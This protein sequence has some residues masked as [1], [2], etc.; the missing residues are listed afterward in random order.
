MSMIESG[1]DSIAMERLS[2]YDRELQ[3]L[4]AGLCSHLSGKTISVHER[5]HPRQALAN[6][7]LSIPLQ[8]SQW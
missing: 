8:S 7:P 6:L 3:V 4:L 5:Q 1:V 2:S